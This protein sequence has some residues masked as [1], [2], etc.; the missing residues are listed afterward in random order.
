MRSVCAWVSWLSLEQVLLQ[1]FADTC[2]A[3]LLIG[4]YLGK[5]RGYA[6]EFL[7]EHGLQGGSLLGTEGLEG[8]DGALERLLDLRI[9]GIGEAEVLMRT[10]DVGHA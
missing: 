1:A 9:L 2:Y 3:S 10:G 4:L 5:Q 7:G 6:V 8:L